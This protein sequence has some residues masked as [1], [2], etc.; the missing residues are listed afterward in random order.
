MTASDELHEL[1]GLK[2]RQLAA[3]PQLP[4]SGQA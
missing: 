1:H 2:P 3:S 4:M